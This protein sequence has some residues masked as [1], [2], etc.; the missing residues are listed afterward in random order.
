MTVNTKPQDH[1]YRDASLIEEFLSH[2]YA[3]N[4]TQQK[5]VEAFFAR[6]PEARTELGEFLSMYQPL[7]KKPA[8]GGL[9]GLAQS[10]VRLL[11][12][13][14]MCRM[15]FMR[16]GTYGAHSQSDAAERVYNNAEQMVPYM[17]GLAVSQY[18]WHSHYQLFRFF[19]HCVELQ[20]PSSRF[21]EVGCGHGIFLNYMASKVAPDAVL[22]VVDISA[23]SIALSKELINATNP[24]VARR[25]RF[26][27]SDVAVY[28]TEKPYDFIAMGE[29]LEHVESPHSILQALKKLMAKD[30]SLYVTT[31]AN[32]PAIDHIY[33]FHTIEEIRVMIRECG[34]KIIEEVVAPSE[35]KPLEY[36]EKHKLDILYGAL[37]KQA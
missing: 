8:I 7:W 33:H 28:H 35:D 31:C 29:V 23:V 30:G 26:T 2:I 21:L 24:A 17:L 11:G 14:M 9:Q 20:N 32:C 12:E 1:A 10:Y 22:D 13:V 18:L 37:L 4:P 36:H 6:T 19:K 25:V 15:D 5:K 34:F 27:E 16:T 3:H